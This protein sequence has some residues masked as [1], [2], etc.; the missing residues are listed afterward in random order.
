MTVFA[1]SRKRPPLSLL[2]VTVGTIGFALV[3]QRNVSLYAYTAMPLFF[4]YLDEP[5]RRLPIWREFR[6][7]FAR[8]ARVAGSWAWVAGACVLLGFVAFKGGVVGGLRVLD[9]EFDKRIFPVEVVRE[10]RA[11]GV[12]GRLFH[13]FAW[14]GWLL[15]AWPEQRVFIDGGTDFYG[16]ELFRTFLAIRDMDPGWRDSLDAYGIRHALLSVQNPLAHEMVRDPEW[17]L[18]TCDATGALLTRG[19]PWT[20]NEA[21]SLV[22]CL[23]AREAPS[24]VPGPD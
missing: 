4:L 11:D 16:S 7:G 6:E 8:G 20:G 5:W 10:A 19:A 2:L 21:D 3:A 14:G 24:T 1:W 9:N 18:R 23:R 13:E 22:S 17:G 15:Y 12:E